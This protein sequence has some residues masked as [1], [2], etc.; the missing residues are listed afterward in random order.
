VSTLYVETS[1]LLR[2]AL[3]GDAILRRRVA[4]HERLVT[5]SLTWVEADR[6]LRR[7]RTSD[8]VGHAR[9]Q[10]AQRWIDSFLASCAE[11]VLDTGVL[12]RA[13]QGFP[14]EP[15]RTLGALHLASILAWDQGIDRLTI[16]S[17]DTRVRDNAHALGFELLPG[18]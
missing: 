9:F 13:R 12:A 5:S 3:E 16:A 8:R 6:A 18:A 17:C 7:A 11:L 4:T 2:V 1:A 14:V 15:V 10:R